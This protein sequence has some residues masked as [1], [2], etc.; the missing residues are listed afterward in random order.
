M[1]NSFVIRG[2]KQL[3][4]TVD[5]RGSKNAALPV[6]AATVLTKKKCRISNLPLVLDV[7]R[8]LKMLDA[9]GSSIRWD[10]SHTVVI[11]NKDIYPARLGR[12][13]VEEMRASILLLGPLLARFGRVE[14]MRYPGG[15]SI[16]A[17]PIDTHLAAFRDLGA[18]IALGKKSFSVEI[19]SRKKMPSEVILNEFSV[20]ATENLLL[21][22][23]SKDSTTRIKIAAAEPHVRDLTR[24]LVKMGAR[25]S[26]A[27]SSTITIRGAG[28]L[29]GVSHRITPDYIEAG[30]FILASLAV[31]G[32][33]YVKDAP[34]GDLDFVIKKL[35]SAGADIRIHPN[36]KLVEVRASFGG[37][38][39]GGKRLKID[40]IQCLPHPGIPTDLQPAFGVLATQVSG[41]TLIHE[42]L[43]EKRLESLME[44]TKMGAHVVLLDP[45]RAVV[46]GPTNLRGANLVCHDLRGG[47]ALAIAGL[48]GKGKTIISNIEHVERGYEDFEGR[49][50][51][52]GADI[53]KI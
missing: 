12:D 46:H 21:F 40:K 47:A 26:G 4:G 3:R 37:A 27:G 28:G 10:G 42:P 22:L 25:C 6:L 33:V 24:V 17:R 8:M 14:K 51:A 50:Q 2:G 49:L 31:G 20:T 13:T 36:K 34:L 18:K 1:A 9:M 11:E 38:G 7:R 16:G 53:K 19:P 45:H 39:K 29:R 30:T 52:L 48:V 15:C 23:A 5:V 44:L 41:R 32:H 35:V 43:Y